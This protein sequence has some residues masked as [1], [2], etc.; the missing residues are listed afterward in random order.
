MGI[1]PPLL[2]LLLDGLPPNV[3]RVDERADISS[4]KW[5][6]Q[7]AKLGAE[8]ARKSR[9]RPLLRDSRKQNSCPGPSQP[10]IRKERKKGKK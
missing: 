8:S 10:S 6:T 9:K 5:R 7:V 3:A 1:K 2:V 4:V